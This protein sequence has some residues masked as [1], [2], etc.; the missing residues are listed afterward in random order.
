MSSDV[1]NAQEM[2]TIATI[3]CAARSQS[4][5]VREAG[6]VTLYD[7]LGVAASATRTEMHRAYRERARRFHPDTQ[8]GPPGGDADAM[9]RLSRAWEILGDPGRRADYDA[10]MRTVGEPLVSGAAW[11]L[12]D[13]DQDLPARHGRLF[14]PLPWLVFG[15]IM[16]AIFVMT[17][18][19]GHRSEPPPPAVVG[20][21]LVAEPG[22]DRFVACPD[23]SPNRVAAV[24]ATAD[25]CPAGTKAH[26]VQ[27]AQ[28]YTACLTGTDPSRPQ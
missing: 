15:V 26:L 13:T 7:E 6:E 28:H 4:A 21:C 19:A 14:S 20:M 27:S 2:S 25:S 22:I 9:A 12:D 3:G 18:Y 1:A 24:A 17:A 5:R 16:T 23:P 8:A 11:D 10:A